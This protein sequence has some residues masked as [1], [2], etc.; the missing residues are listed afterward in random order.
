[1]PPKKR[2]E[3]IRPAILLELACHALMGTTL[4]L[5]FAF[6]LTKLD[7]FGIASLITHSVEPMMTVTIFVSVMTLSFAVGATLTGFV[8]TMMEER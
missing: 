7:A 1:M 5:G 4:G 3:L 2:R 8:F 6:A